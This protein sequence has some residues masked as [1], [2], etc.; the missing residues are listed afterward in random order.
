M[1]ISGSARKHGVTDAAIIHAYE[2]AIR[3]REYEFEGEERI[4]IIGPDPSGALL[5]LIAIPA[6]TP[7]RIIHA[8]R[9]RPKFYDNL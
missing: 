7:N 6:G 1:E 5:E 8:D 3:I 9:L 2:H 4:L